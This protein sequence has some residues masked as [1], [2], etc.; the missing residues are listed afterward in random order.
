MQEI[1]ELT[2]LESACGTT[3]NLICEWV[4]ER[5]DSD[6][7]ARLADWFIDR[8]LRVV[9]ILVMAWF[10]A[11]VGRRFVSRF[12]SEVAERSARQRRD[13]VEEN[14]LLRRVSRLAQH[15]QQTARTK[16]RAFSVC[17]SLF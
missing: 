8:P 17:C 14:P 7:W 4:F 11:R 12:A 2:P 15:K 6:V 3:P 13:E 1:V 16:R 9:L 5:S 10:A